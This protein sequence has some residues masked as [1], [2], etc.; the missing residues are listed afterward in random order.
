[1]AESTKMKSLIK[2]IFYA[3]LGLYII[4]YFLVNAV[5]EAT[6][7]ENLTAF[8]PLISLVIVVAVISLVWILF[9]NAL[10]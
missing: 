3:G 2:D 8:S 5:W 4:V 1:M 7:N 6:N 9:G 10:K